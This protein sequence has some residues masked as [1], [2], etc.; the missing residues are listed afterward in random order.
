MSRERRR[1]NAFKVVGLLVTALR[2]VSEVSAS[3]TIRAGCS[4]HLALFI[5]GPLF[6]SLMFCTSLQVPHKGFFWLLLF[7]QGRKQHTQRC[8]ASPAVFIY[9]PL[10]HRCTA[11]AVHVSL[12]LL[13][14][15]PSFIRR[16]AMALSDNP[17][18]FNF[19]IRGNTLCLNAVAFS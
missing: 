1:Y 10:R 11:A 9:A 7:R 19:S 3:F 13:V 17:S 5:S 6:H 12:P 2:S 8:P 16:S 18:P 4:Y 15:T 14:F